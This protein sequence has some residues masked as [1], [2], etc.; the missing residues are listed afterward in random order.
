MHSA[1]LAAK[2]GTAACAACVDDVVACGAV[3]LD[4]E[5][6]SEQPSFVFRLLREASLERA[7][8]V[9]EGD[10]RPAIHDW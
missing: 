7:D 1:A 3:M 9:L 8:A 5:D 2:S 4:L 10:G 6:A